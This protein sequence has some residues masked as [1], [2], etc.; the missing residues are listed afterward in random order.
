MR[1]PRKQKASNASAFPTARPRALNAGA[2]RRSAGSAMARN[3]GPD[4]RGASALRSG[5]MG[6]TVAATKATLRHRSIGV[7]EFY[8]PNRPIGI[9][10]RFRCLVPDD[11]PNEVFAVRRSLLDGF[12]DRQF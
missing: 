2:S 7:A 4:A 6:L 9:E 10:M 3:G 5:G 12:Q 1:Q 8:S 11:H